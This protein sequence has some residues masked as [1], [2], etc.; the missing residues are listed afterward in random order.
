VTNSNEEPPDLKRLLTVR[1]SAAGEVLVVT[2]VGELDIQTAP[3]L[4][5]AIGNAVAGSGG[6]RLALDLT[7]VSFM[8]S[9][10]LA[11]LLETARR[12]TQLQGWLRLVIDPDSAAF[13]A[14]EV[15]GLHKV[16]TLYGTLD[17]ALAD[18]AAAR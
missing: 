14:L 3:V 18:D 2:A 10:G 13:E 6:S 15:T 17:E 11:L 9:T 5:E 12:L 1:S 4:R 7:G 16:L 8:G